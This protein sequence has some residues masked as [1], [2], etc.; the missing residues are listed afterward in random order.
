[1]DF[2]FNS[3]EWKIKQTKKNWNVQKRPPLCT[4]WPVS[5]SGK[6]DVLFVKVPPKSCHFG[7]R[8]INTCSQ[9][10]DFLIEVWRKKASRLVTSKMFSELESY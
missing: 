3:T 2:W 6:D 4:E 1:M 7:A 5:L 8:L 10:S 9:L